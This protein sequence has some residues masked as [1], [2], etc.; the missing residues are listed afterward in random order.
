MPQAFHAIVT[1]KPCI[2]AD[3]VDVSLLLRQR[4]WT[5]YRLHLEREQNAWVAAVI[6]WQHAA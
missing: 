5:P 6:D 1:R 4:G 3:A 2:T